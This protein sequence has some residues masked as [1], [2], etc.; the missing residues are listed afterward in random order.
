MPRTNACGLSAEA[1]TGQ[2]L[3]GGRSGPPETKFGATARSSGNEVL[4]KSDGAASVGALLGSGVAEQNA[5]HRL[6]VPSAALPCA[7]ELACS[8]S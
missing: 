4:V 2:M 3:R 5:A 8:W 6:H 1:E 7:L